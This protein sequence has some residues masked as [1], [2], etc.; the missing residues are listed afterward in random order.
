MAALIVPLALWALSAS[1]PGAP[2]AP[3]PAPG[4][5]GPA[6]PLPTGGLAGCSS[7]CI[8][9]WR[10]AMEQ[11]SSPLHVQ[12]SGS[13][14]PPVAGLMRRHRVQSAF[15]GRPALDA[16]CASWFDAIG[17][18]FHDSHLYGVAS[19]GYT[20]VRIEHIDLCGQCDQN[21]VF[22]GWS[23]PRTQ[24]SGQLA[25]RS[26][27]EVSVQIQ[28]WF[29]LLSGANNHLSIV[30]R[31]SN[32]GFAGSVT[33]GL[34]YN[35]TLVPYVALSMGGTAATAT[36][37]MDR[38]YMAPWN[39]DSKPGL[40]EVVTL[41]GSVSS[42]GSAIQ[43]F[44]WASPSS[45]AMGVRNSLHAAGVR[46]RCV[47]HPLIPPAAGGSGGGGTPG[48]TPVPGSG[49]GES[50]IPGREGAEVRDRDPLAPPGSPEEEAGPVIGPL[51][52]EQE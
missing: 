38:I 43:T 48:W 22:S 26:S 19:R 11:G 5:S 51:K 25:G 21:S 42:H 37:P 28:A 27:Y 20:R 9:K 13:E 3:A 31:G 39:S 50:A 33:G 30:E 8:C 34:S 46:F 52:E 12:P 6:Q 15:M 1:L 29:H 44:P 7:S 17:S 40:E 24:I 4:S 14:I 45:A 49:G 18:E 23:Q 35:G 47:C 41:L 10:V 2:Q 32:G 36:Q 16:D